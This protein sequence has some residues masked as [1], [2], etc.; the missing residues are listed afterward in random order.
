MIK[1][2]NQLPL[3]LHYCLNRKELDPKTIKAYRIDLTQFFQ[4]LSERGM[5]M[6]KDGINQY[7]FYVHERYKQRTVKRKIASLKAFI[8]YLE[9]EEIIEENP[10]RKINTKFKEEIILP[11]T[12]PRDIVEHLLRKMYE[13]KEKDMTANEKRF[14]IRDIAVVEFL[15]ATGLRVSELS[16]LRREDMDLHTGIFLIKGKGSKERYMQIENRE[17]QKA[18]EEY[19]SLF[20]DK[21]GQQE[22]F[23][24]NK[25]GNRLSEQAVRIM[26][27]KHVEKAGIPAHLTPH[28]FRHAFATLLLEEDV[29]IR[30][31]QKMLGHSSIVTTQIYTYVAVEKQK[32]ILRLKHPRN[33]MRIC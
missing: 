2:Q 21:I 27:R 23:F 29:D 26:L 30:Y 31:I 4:Y 13:E 25:W 12:I 28:M 20:Q 24:L 6:D 18:I 22:Y 8:G 10:F 16:A 5:E 7:L 32:E 15:F 14:L 19:Y 9:Y 17:V 1:Y 11:R 33:K 3:Y